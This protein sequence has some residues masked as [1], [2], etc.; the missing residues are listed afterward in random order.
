MA[1]TGTADLAPGAA[2]PLHSTSRAWTETN[3]YVDVWVELLHS[4]G[5][6][7]VPAAVCALSAD[8][9]GDQWTFLKFAPEDLRV[10]YGISVAEMNVWRPVRDHVVEQLAAGRLTTVEAD[11]WWLPDTAGVSYRTEHVKS[12]IVPLEVDVEGERLVYL[13]NAGRFELGGEDFRNVFELR[14]ERAV[15]PPYVE[16]LRLD[17]LVVRD[18]LAEATA[19]LAHDHL[20]RRP[21]DNPVD[22]LGERLRADLPWLREAGLE[23]FHTY[24]FGV[25]RQFGVTAELAGDLVEW[26]T[27]HGEAE[28]TDAAASF[29]AA[30]GAAKTLQFR[31]ARAVAGREVDLDSLVAAMSVPW[32]EAMAATVAWHEA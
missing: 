29:R 21:L 11:S 6:D 4:L 3:C 8:F 20:D 14:G 32:S 31:L 15:L 7:P 17:R 24:A 5:L 16:L 18:D 19:A 12:T 10:L 30:A 2:H 23:T 26:L 1:V 22:R 27:A 25:V 9:V 13:H 28:L